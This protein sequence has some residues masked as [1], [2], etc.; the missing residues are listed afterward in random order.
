VIA[1]KVEAE[2]QV[3]D[4]LELDVRYGQGHLFG[5]PRAIKDAVLAETDPPA[6]FLRPT[7]Q[8]RVAMGR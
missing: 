4:V 5:E 8:R 2:R 1:E 6:A 7:L 3:V